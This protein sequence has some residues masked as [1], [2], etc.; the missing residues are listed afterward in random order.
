MCFLVYSVEDLCACFP[1]DLGERVILQLKGMLFRHSINGGFG[2]FNLPES[3]VNPYIL[4]HIRQLAKQSIDPCQAFREQIVHS[5][6]DRPFMS[7]HVVYKDSVTQLANALDPSF[8]LFQSGR[9]SREVRINKRTELLQVQSF[10][11]RVCAKQQSKFS[12]LYH[13]F[14]FFS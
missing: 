14:E 8:A 4:K 12:S 11:C 13:V 6:F 2:A 9:I 10:T 5:V 3:Y 7:P 1:R